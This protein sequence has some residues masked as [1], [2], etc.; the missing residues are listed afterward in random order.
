MEHWPD[1][2]GSLRSLT[3]LLKDGAIGLIEVPNFDFILQK[4]LYSEFTTDHIFYFTEKTLRTVLEI[5]GFDVLEVNTIWHDY[6]LSAQVKKRTSQNIS[7]FGQ[8][9]KKVITEIIKF[10]E[11]FK[12]IGRAHV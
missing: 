8:Q 5:N 9:Q 1:I 6:I 2:N 11:L 3:I 12:K 4:G 10:I 7:N